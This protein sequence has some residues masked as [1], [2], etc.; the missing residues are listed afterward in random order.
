[1]KA[2]EA[3]SLEELELVSGGGLIDTGNVEKAAEDLREI[4]HDLFG[5]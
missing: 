3:L 2:M 1:M 4:L 5:W